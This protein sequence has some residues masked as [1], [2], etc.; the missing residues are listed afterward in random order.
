MLESIRKGSLMV[1]GCILGLME[2]FIR[3]ILYRV[4]E[5]VRGCGRK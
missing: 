4:R 2:M 5:R 1:M 3:E